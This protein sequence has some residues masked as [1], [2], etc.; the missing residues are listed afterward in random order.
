MTTK[1]SIHSLDG[2]LR[3]DKD[4][5]FVLKPMLQLGASHGEDSDRSIELVWFAHAKRRRWSVR[6]REHNRI[7]WASLK[8]KE[9]DTLTI[10]GNVFYRLRARVSAV[11]PGKRFEYELSLDEKVVFHAVGKSAVAGADAHRV[12][13]FGDFADGDKGA[14]AI[15]KATLA[16]DADLLVFAGDVVYNS[17][18][19]AEYRTHLDP[20]VNDEGEKGVP[21]LRSLVSV[22]VP[23]NHDIRVPDRFDLM[24]HSSSSDLFAFFRTWRHPKNGPQ[25]KAKEVEKMSKRGK[26]GKKLFDTFGSQYVRWGN[27]YFDYGDARW[28]MLDAN[29]YIDWRN[30]DLQK[31]VRDKLK[32]ARHKRWKFVCFHQPGFNSD[33]KYKT[34]TRMRVLSPLFEEFGVDIV[35]SGHCHFYERSFPLKCELNP[36]GKAKLRPDGT[37]HLD[38]NFDG[39]KNRTPKGVIYIVSGAGGLLVSE[40]MKPSK[41]GL[42]PSCHK[43]KD[44]KNSFTVLD[45]GRKTLTVRQLDTDGVEL[46]RF[47]IEK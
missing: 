47:C 8:V 44:D 34:D 37:L 32:E 31:W 21:L 22:A 45:L 41:R 38:K 28:L 39:V 9:I 36:K 13:V 25:L 14:S 19:F 26:S 12:V 46:D 33:V 4:K 42:S 11:S 40:G 16:T 30:E 1:N 35:F 15:A 27:Y 10:N 20:V 18:L 3:S 6:V 17:G 7:R 23:G 2:E 24:Q 29:E 43:V 5:P